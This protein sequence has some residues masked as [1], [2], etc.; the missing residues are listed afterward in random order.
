MEKPKGKRELKTEQ[1]RQTILDVSLRL[2]RRYGFERTSIQDIC[3][4]ANVSV[5]SLYHLFDS[6]TAI[7]NYILRRVDSFYVDENPIDYEKE[8]PEIICSLM[9]EKFNTLV[10]TLTPEIV[11]QALFSSAQGNKT[12]FYKK[13]GSIVWMRDHF[14]GFRDVGKVKD[15]MDIEQ[16]VTMINTCTIGLFY[17]LYTME[18]LDSLRDELEDLVVRLFHSYNS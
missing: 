13:R 4:E 16:M 9:A 3:R 5:G 17:R 18:E 15:E 8:E 12:M 7:I 14:N 6:K 1:T 10:T 11:Y 2:F